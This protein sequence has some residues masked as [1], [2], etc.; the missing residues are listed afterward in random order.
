MV[1]ERIR[2]QE[3]ESSS[4][5]PPEDSSEE[6]SHDSDDDHEVEGNVGEGG[7]RN[8]GN[9]DAEGN[10]DEIT[11]EQ[12]LG[13]VGGEVPGAAAERRNQRGSRKPG[14][15]GDIRKIN[16]VQK[17]GPFEG[18]PTEGDVL[19]K[20]YDHVA[21]RV[22]YGEERGA[23]TCVHHTHRLAQ[24]DV[25]T[26]SKRFTEVV[27]STGLDILAGTAQ[28]VDRAMI[29]AFVERWHEETSSFHLPFGEMTITLEDMFLITGLKIDGKMPLTQKLSKD[30]A[31]ALVNRCLGI[32]VDEVKAQFN[33]KE[34]GGTNLRLSWLQ[35]KITSIVEVPGNDDTP[36]T[37]HK[38]RGYL[39]YAIGMLLC[40]NKS[41]NK[42]DSC[43]LQL[44][45]DI[46][47]VASVPW[48]VIGLAYLYDQL[49]SA[50]KGS[51]VSISGF[52]AV[53]EVKLMF[54]GHYFDVLFLCMIC[55]YIV[56]LDV[57]FGAFPWIIHSPIPKDMGSRS[58]THFTVETT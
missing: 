22:W 11:V 1:M 55:C 27:K 39:L 20:F 21:L 24:W 13:D 34:I 4:Q 48:G 43:Y 26:Y 37:D 10:V 9:V 31:A 33:K 32:D 25:S 40:C 15:D 6:E 18:G 17:K 28:V 7:D 52:L 53:V 46:E 16:N 54:L 38:I 49:N 29:S 5:M 2:R 42:V 14:K 36:E 41:G 19:K 56:C 45:E 57:D 47:E 23:L 35:E 50:C 58:A 3:I 12:V 51:V 44:L 8:E 30:E